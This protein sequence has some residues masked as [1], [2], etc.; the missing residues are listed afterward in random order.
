MVARDSE[1]KG[2]GV[3]VFWRRGLN[4]ELRNFSRF[5]M[6]QEIKEE[7]GFKWRSIGM[8]GELRAENKFL[9]WKLMTILHNEASL[10]WLCMGDFNKVL[11]VDEKEGRNEKA[12]ACMGIFRGALEVWGLEDLGFE[13]ANSPGGTTITARRTISSIDWIGLSQMR[14]GGSSLRSLRL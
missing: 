4:V 1:G 2:C 5:H 10:P 6:D 3:A 12:Q 11:F 14:D 8:Y 9:T 13:G 7:D